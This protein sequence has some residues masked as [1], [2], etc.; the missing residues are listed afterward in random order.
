VVARSAAWAAARG[1]V[2]EEADGS[3]RGSIQLL[4]LNPAFKPINLVPEDTDALTIV[5]GVVRVA[6]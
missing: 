6:P 3:W 5:G 2:E 1:S 4:P